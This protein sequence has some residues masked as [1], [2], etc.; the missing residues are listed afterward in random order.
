MPTSKTSR[1][2]LLTLFF[3]SS[4][5]AGYAYRRGQARQHLVLAHFATLTTDLAAANQQLAQANA[6]TMRYVSRSAYLNHYY[7]PYLQV[8]RTSERIWTRAHSLADTLRVIRQS[9][10]SQAELRLPQGQPAQDWRIPLRE[11]LDRYA[12][13]IQQAIPDASVKAATSWPTAD[14]PAQATPL[15]VTLAFLTELETQVRQRETSA[16]QLQAEQ[17]GSK[18]WVCSRI[19]ATAIPTATAVAPGAVYEAQLLL[20]ETPVAEFGS[21]ILAANGKLLPARNGAGAL[22][23]LRAAPWHPGQPDTVRA[24][25]HGTIRAH[26]YPADSTW[27]LDVPYLIVKRPTL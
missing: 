4:L 8:L 19:E 6:A 21:V 20:L 7:G 24:Q 26:S 12:A 17:I 9:L 14:W 25:W 2:L 10:G 18:C 27:Q 11:K 13:F 22:V 1:L 23:E 16:L 5:L 3:M 15:P